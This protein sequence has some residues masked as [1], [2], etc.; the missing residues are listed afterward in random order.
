M[1][2]AICIAV[3]VAGCITD[4]VQP[5]GD[6]ICPV[7]QVCVDEARCV[8]PD[9]VAVCDSAA[10]GA[11]CNVGGV[12]GRCTDHP[13]LRVCDPA[14]CGDGVIDSVLHEE[15]DGSAAF[16]EQCADLGFDL[17]R[18]TCASDCTF[19]TSGC[20]EFGW[21]RVVNASVY[22]LWTDGTVV[23][24]GH[25]DPDG[26]EVHGGG[27]NVSMSRFAGQ[28]AGGGG[29]IYA[30]LDDNRAYEVQSGSVVDLEMPAGG[31]ING[32]AVDPRDGT[33]YATQ[34]C[35]LWAYNGTWTNVYGSPSLCPEIASITPDGRLYFIGATNTIYELVAGA[36]VARFGTS[37][38]LNLLRTASSTQI[39]V[40]GNT[41]VWGWNG[42]GSPTEI[43][44]GDVRSI[45]LVGN[46]VYGTFSDGSG[47]R[48]NPART[49][50]G[51][52]RRR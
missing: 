35:N 10:A 23:A 11:A 49:S 34:M 47:I 4:Q 9:A 24:Y 15:C 43:S 19:D 52:R 2:G 16:D 40:G 13:P 17:G 37:G 27:W 26:L 20:T 31:D 36:P 18:P 44:P 5:C 48:Y 30:V 39:I 41:G 21:D 50:I 32:L 45:A 28:L 42:S 22:T 3:L 51:S 14:V 7:D 8:S 33:L 25:H 6:Q 1:R 29:H 38:A 46:D 12:P